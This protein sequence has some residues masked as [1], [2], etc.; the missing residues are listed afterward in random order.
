MD[1]VS[2]ALEET[3]F[4]HG[5]IPCDLLHPGFLGIR[6]GVTP[7]RTFRFD[8]VD[9]RHV[10]TALHVGATN[11]EKLGYQYII[12]MNSDTVPAKLP[13]D[14]D[15]SKHVLPI[16]LTDDTEDGGLFGIRLG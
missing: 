13:E 5:D 9:E 7:S 11:A 4:I 3:P 15:L 6:R 12:T 14:F 1:E 8:G 16:R 10:A 2:P